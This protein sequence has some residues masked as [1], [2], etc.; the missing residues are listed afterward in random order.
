MKEILLTQGKVALVDDDVDL[1]ALAEYVW[2]AAYHPSSQTWYAKAIVRLGVTVKTV[3]MHRL[4]TG[5]KAKQKVDH[6][7]H[8]GLHNTGDN[9]RLGTQS[10]NLANM[11]I[12]D[13]NHSGYKGVHWDK[14]RKKWFASIKTSQKKIALGRYNTIQEAACAYDAAAIG[15][16][17]DRALTNKMLGLL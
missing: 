17:G 10:Q 2:I 13:A 3:Y 7:D 11:R 9:L 4:I 8:D 15:Y 14:E 12:T 5:A 1:L 16:Y 6:I